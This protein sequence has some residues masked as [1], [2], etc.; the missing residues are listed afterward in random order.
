MVTTMDHKQF[1]SPPAGHCLTLH[2]AWD[3][4]K[5]CCVEKKDRK[6]SFD[7]FHHLETGLMNK[8]CNGK[9]LAAFPSPFLPQVLDKCSGRKGGEQIPETATMYPQECPPFQMITVLLQDLSRY[10]SLLF[11]PGY[12]STHKWKPMNSLLPSRAH[13][14]QVAYA[15]NMVHAL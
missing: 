6:D 10:A 3:G 4:T 15:G 9:T 5:S 7:S 11:S 8:V 1:Y 13:Q 12:K 2:A 14:V